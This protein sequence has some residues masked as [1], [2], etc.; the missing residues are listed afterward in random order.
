MKPYLTDTDFSKADRALHSINDFSVYEVGIN[1][2]L[3]LV[4]FGDYGEHRGRINEL[5][6]HLSHQEAPRVGFVTPYQ[7]TI[8]EVGVA[9]LQ[10][11]ARPGGVGLSA[12][13]EL[14]VLDVLFQGVEGAEYF[15]HSVRVIED[16]ITC[17]C[18]HALS[19]SPGFFG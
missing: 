1:K 9:Q 8:W 18:L 19:V 12:H 4:L 7:R 3:A 10:V 2:S 13:R 11:S 15:L 14:H 6:M 5:T 16:I 17:V